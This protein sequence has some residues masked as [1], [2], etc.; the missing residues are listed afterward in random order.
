MSEEMTA[1]AGDLSGMW[2]LQNRPPLH[3][4]T[5]DWWW[6]LVMLEDPDA[7][8]CDQAYLPDCCYA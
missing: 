4:L 6:W 7:R 8:T 3:H 2:T 5:W 1:F